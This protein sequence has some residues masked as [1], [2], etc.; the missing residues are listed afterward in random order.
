M[1]GGFSSQSEQHPSVEDMR[2]VGNGS[3]DTNSPRHEKTM[4]KGPFVYRDLPQE[5]SDYE[6][7]RTPPT[8]PPRKYSRRGA[9]L[10][11]HCIGKQDSDENPLM[12]HPH[13]A[14]PLKLAQAQD[15]ENKKNNKK[16]RKAMAVAGMGS[17]GR[18]RSIDHPKVLR[19]PP[20]SPH[21]VRASYHTVQP[22]ML[23]HALASRVSSS[24]GDSGSPQDPQHPQYYAEDA[25]VNSP[26]RRSPPGPQHM[27]QRHEHLRGSAEN[28][29]GKILESEGLGQYI[30]PRC[31]NREIAEAHDLTEQE[32]DRAARELTRGGPGPSGPGG[33]PNK[34]PY[35]DH[36]G[37]Y[38]M[39]DMKDYNQYS[40]Q[41]SQYTPNTHDYSPD[42]QDL[43][44]S[45]QDADQMLYVTTL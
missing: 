24:E 30:D 39:H 42:S 21:R 13:V 22:L 23:S 36:L 40:Q 32:L 27:L 37:G 5:D 15:K 16:N 45:D 38:S 12:K 9:S 26:R 3:S 25:P 28:L 33:S 44:G 10:K 4:R 6:R 2:I 31:L 1:E 7:E 29:V 19:T 20:D 34:L 18:H 14:T 17:D 8:P 43:S 41:D 35:Y 11:L